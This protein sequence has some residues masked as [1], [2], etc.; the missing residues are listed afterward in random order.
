MRA[1]HFNITTSLKGRFGEPIGEP[2][3]V[4]YGMDGKHDGPKAIKC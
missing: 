2:Y 4:G 1:F 3:S